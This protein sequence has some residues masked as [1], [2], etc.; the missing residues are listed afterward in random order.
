MRIHA[1]TLA[2]LG[3]A[4]FASPATQAAP[5]ASVKTASDTLIDARLCLVVY[6]GE[7]LAKIDTLTNPGVLFI[8]K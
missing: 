4:I 2:L 3:L 6:S 1:A 5:A 7:P 8:L